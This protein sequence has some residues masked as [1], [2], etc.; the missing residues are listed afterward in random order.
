MSKKAS[1]AV[2]DVVMVRLAL[3]VGM[4]AYRADPT[5]EE[6]VQMRAAHN[7][8][9]VAQKAL[10]DARHTDPA[11]REVAA[12]S[13]SEEYWLYPRRRKAT[14]TY[15]D[16]SGG[17]IDILPSGAPG[18]MKPTVTGS[19]NV[20][21]KTVGSTVLQ[22]SVGHWPK[23]AQETFRLDTL[24]WFDE[25]PADAQDR[26]VAYPVPD[27]DAPAVRPSNPVTA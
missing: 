22:P 20:E 7:G 4:P 10:L 15:V 12:L 8:D 17:G 11:M 6:L 26:H 16:R 3:L 25:E 14:V 27:P 24:Q 18:A 5:D 13:L 2:G 19:I 9:T 21:V 1:V 23:W